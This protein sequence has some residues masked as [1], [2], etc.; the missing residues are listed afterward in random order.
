MHVQ[1]T[2]WEENKTAII[3]TALGLPKTATAAEITREAQ[4]QGHDGVV[5]DY[6]PLG[7][8]HQEV[9]AFDPKQTAIT[10][11][12]TTEVRAL[13]DVEGHEFHGNQWTTGSSNAIAETYGTTKLP[14]AANFLLRDGRMV[15]SNSMHHSL[16]AERVGV[17]LGDLEQEGVIR[18]IPGGAE[19]AH[20]P[21]SEQAKLLA[22]HWTSDKEHSDHVLDVTA[23]RQTLGSIVFKG[24]IT[25]D[26]IRSFTRRALKNSKDDPPLYEVRHLGDV[27]GHEFHGNQYTAGYHVTFTK[28]VPGIN[29]KGI[30]Q[31]HDSNWVKGSPTGERYGQGEVYAFEHPGDA[32]QWAGKMDFHLNREFGSGKISVVKFDA[33]GWKGW[34]Q[35]TS[36][37]I[38]QAGAA[39][40]W[41]KKEGG[42]LPEDIKGAVAIT[43]EHT[44][45]IR[46]RVERKDMTLKGLKGKGQ[47]PKMSIEFNMPNDAAAEWAREHGGELIDGITDETRDRINEAVASAHEDGDLEDMRAEIE[48]AVGDDARAEM[49]G[50]TESMAAANEGQREGW[51]Q[52]AEEGLLPPGYKRVWIATSDACPECDDLNGETTDEDGTYPDDG[53]DGP[54]LHPN[55]RCT[56]GIAE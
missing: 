29:K 44:A 54:P 32:L 40:K 17:S 49:I 16:Q 38:S 23:G 45:Q 6:S 56:E 11:V 5:L 14:E 37:P 39:G 51:E 52:A 2:K 42:V 22:D 26:A 36:D 35:D 10:H 7:Y 46:S 20:E 30:Q 33:K 27:P 21:T 18:L 25:A 53:E 4:K 31:F 47:G 8:H 34:N 55:C 24:R 15:R 13:G 1:A 48:D 28:S 3:T 41:Y 19:V 12:D 50:R 43:T 9:V